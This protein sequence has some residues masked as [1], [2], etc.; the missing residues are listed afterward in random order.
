MIYA[1]KKI[2]ETPHQAAQNAKVIQTMLQLQEKEWVRITG[3]TVWLKKD[4][5][6]NVLLAQNWMRCAH[7]YGILLLKYPKK[8]PMQFRDIDTDVLIGTLY[9]K[10]IQVLLF[11]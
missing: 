5:W 2:Q 8:S 1:K 6:K 11:R 3:Q 10:Q 9:G 7:I 4:L